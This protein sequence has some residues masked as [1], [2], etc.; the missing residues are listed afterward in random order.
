VIPILTEEKIKTVHMKAARERYTKHC[1][2]T[3][4]DKLYCNWARNT[5]FYLWP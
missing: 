4:C 2:E 1:M 5:D 3:S